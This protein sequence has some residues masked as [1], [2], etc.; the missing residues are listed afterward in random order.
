MLSHD[1]D[2][3]PGRSIRLQVP[4]A[5]LRHGT[6]QAR[7]FVRSFRS[8]CGEGAERRA[9]ARKRDRKYRFDDSRRSAQCVFHGPSGGR[10]FSGLAGTRSAIA[11]RERGTNLA[12]T[13]ATIG[14]PL[15][16]SRRDEG[17]SSIDRPTGPRGTLS[18]GLSRSTTARR[19]QGA[20]SDALPID[21]MN[22][23]YSI[24]QGRQAERLDPRTE[25]VASPYGAWDWDSSGSLA[26]ASEVTFRQTVS[27]PL[28]THL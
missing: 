16:G 5:F 13:T 12:T 9:D 3:R 22:P 11:G 24:P 17:R 10:P 6:F 15:Q 23:S 14:S 1:V 20:G 4:A 2:G 7:L 8:G 21:G 18:P 26:E 27:S 28:S 19:R 25:T